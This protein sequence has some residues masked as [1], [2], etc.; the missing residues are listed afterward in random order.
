MKKPAYEQIQARKGKARLGMLQ[1]AQRISGNVSQTCGSSES[2]GRS[3]I[4]GRNAM[5]RIA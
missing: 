1:H 4:S 2:L 3:S 5:K